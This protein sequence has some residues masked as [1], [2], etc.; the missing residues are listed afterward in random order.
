MSRLPNPEDHRKSDYPVEP[1]F[2]RRW[3]PRAMNGEPLTEEEVWDL[4]PGDEAIW[5]YQ[6]V[7]YFAAKVVERFCKKHGLDLRA[8]AAQGGGHVR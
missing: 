6:D 1:I 3:S 2:I 8:P 4:G 5:V 7:Q